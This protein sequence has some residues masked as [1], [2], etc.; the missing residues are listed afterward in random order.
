MSYQNEKQTQGIPDEEKASP[1]ERFVPDRRSFVVPNSLMMSL[2]TAPPPGT[3]NC[4]MREMLSDRESAAEDEANRLSSGILSGT[5]NSVRKEMGRRLGADF[6]AVRFHTGP[7][8]I[9][10]N[11]S[12]GSRAFTR[13]NDV[14]FGR[15]GF[16]PVVG[17]HE[18]VHTV[19]Q[20]AIPGNV[21]RAVPTGT[22]QM[23]SFRETK[24]GSWLHG[25]REHFRRHRRKGKEELKAEAGTLKASSGESKDLERT[26][27]A[28]PIAEGID[29]AVFPPETKPESTTKDDM[30]DLPVFKP[31]PVKAER[32]ADSGLPAAPSASVIPEPAFS[33][34]PEEL[35]S[36]V[37]SEIKAGLKQQGEE[38][39]EINDTVG[40]VKKSLAGAP[41]VP[42][43]ASPELS[44]EPESVPS[45]SEAED[46]P[47]S[48]LNLPLQGEA[49]V[50][51]D[52]DD[53]DDAEV[54]DF[55]E[56]YAEL[57]REEQAEDRGKDD[58]VS[59]PER[60]ASAA[61]IEAESLEEMEARLERLLAERT[62]LIKRL[63]SAE[64]GESS[65]DDRTKSPVHPAAP[66]AP[67]VSAPPIL[68]DAES[69]R[70][71]DSED[72]EEFEEEDVARL[73]GTGR[74]PSLEEVD[75][76]PTEKSARFHRR[77]GGRYHSQ[78]AAMGTVKEGTAYVNA[79]NSLVSGFNSLD[80][81][82]AMGLDYAAGF[83]KPET[84]PYSIDYHKNEG[85]ALT[86]ATAFASAGTAAVS[87][88]TNAAD[89]VR[90]IQNIE[91]GESRFDAA[92]SSLDTLSS[93]GTFLSSGAKALETVGAMT[94]A[95][96]FIP[97]MNIATGTLTLVSGASQGIRGGVALYR[98]NREIRF[99]ERR[100]M[101]E[102]RRR[103]EE[104]D[105]EES[106]AAPTAAS[107]TAKDLHHGKG[108]N[109]ARTRKL[110]YIF[111]HG[112]W[113][114]EYNRT[115]GLMKAGSGVLTI[116]SGAA[117]LTGAG[118]AIGAGLG[119][120]SAGLGVGRFA[121]DKI[122]KRHIR[123]RVIAQELGINTSDLDDADKRRATLEASRFGVSS[124]KDAFRIIRKER[125]KFLLDL[126]GRDAP[127]DPEEDDENAI[128]AEHVIRALGVYRMKDGSYADGA[129]DLLAEK[130]G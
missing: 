107:V 5:P 95:A 7:E 63:E 9:R 84:G 35:P 20:R 64:E 91:A 32:G 58:A 15:G 111:D 120:A 106:G 100:I 126:A 45:E 56:A 67:P 38:D 123:H 48:F 28:P 118:A 79:G 77:R 108:F 12:I 125:A 124:S 30:G 72:E 42:S 46:V 92:Q 73:I 74:S 99:L 86:G 89:A 26:I 129:E 31:V 119:A 10:K 51:D 1:E 55:E 105:D 52:S 97:G 25:I 70:I 104:L 16:D 40:R 80:E 81:L 65:S 21:S 6:S 102:N 88:V 62:E 94:P 117:T 85:P 41:A 103:R 22:V 113:V 109:D 4:V 75:E 57:L 71:P 98:I 33:P 53:D 122:K 68:H 101:Q 59:D 112:K 36:A 50:P 114:S 29:K 39:S 14:W 82:S 27:S 110:M 23:F 66:A 34:Q 87:T 127:P 69:D 76:D 18:L 24:L 2:P 19:Q 60:S 13:G 44:P 130:L 17:A 90:H 116:G 47:T 115:A 8:S 54:V 83:E 43:S 121:Y 96:D 3:P 93:A 49:I 78:S 128:A 11:E 61:G 37:E